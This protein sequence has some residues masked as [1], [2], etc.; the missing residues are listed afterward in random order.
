MVEREGGGG[1]GGEWGESGSPP[2]TSGLAVA[3]TWGVE[4]RA[5][6]RAAPCRACSRQRKEGWISGVVV[7]I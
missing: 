6:V 7:G 2:P 5:C 3:E 4:K 1:W